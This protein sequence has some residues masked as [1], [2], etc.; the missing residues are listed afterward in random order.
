[1]DYQ[2]ELDDELLD[3]DVGLAKFDVE[4]NIEGL[5]RDALK[6]L[7]EF[8]ILELIILEDL[9]VQCSDVGDAFAEPPSDLS[10]FK[11]LNSPHP[12]KIQ[13]FKQA[14]YLLEDGRVEHID[15]LEAI[16]HGL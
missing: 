3:F 5:L 4:V 13:S 8:Y 15:D 16:L 1:M 14:D 9:A 10:P 12:D 11:E 7:V 2:R 6:V